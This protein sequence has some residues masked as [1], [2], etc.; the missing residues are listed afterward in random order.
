[1]CACIS[2]VQALGALLDNTALLA[3]SWWG[4]NV[5]LCRSALLLSGERSPLY[6]A[7][8][9]CSQ[10]ATP[11]ASRIQTEIKPRKLLSIPHGGSR[12]MEGGSGLHPVVSSRKAGSQQ[13]QPVQT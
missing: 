7:G 1:M 2:D 11:A 9:C 12:A 5:L 13:Q 8:L 6:S 10:G 4:I 3:G